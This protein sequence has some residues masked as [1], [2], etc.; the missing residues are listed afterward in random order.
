MALFCLEPSVAPPCPR[1]IPAPGSSHAQVLPGSCQGLF[2][3]PPPAQ[4]SPQGLLLTHMSHFPLGCR[5]SLTPPAWMGSPPTPRFSLRATTLT[6]PSRVSPSRASTELQ[7]GRSR[8]GRGSC[9]GPVVPA[10]APWSWCRPPW[11]LR[12]EQT[13]VSCG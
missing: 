4:P 10:M 3:Q 12:G 9:C 8:V 2:R 7:Q 1:L 13:M 5:A 6:L 11:D